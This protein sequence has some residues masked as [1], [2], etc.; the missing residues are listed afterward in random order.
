MRVLRVFTTTAA[1]TCVLWMY[2]YV[3]RAYK[4]LHHIS[5]QLDSLQQHHTHG[6]QDWGELQ[7]T[8]EGTYLV[9]TLAR[10]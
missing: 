2:K 4:D 1:A 5:T 9:G 8:A 6:M 7:A 10:H 3:S